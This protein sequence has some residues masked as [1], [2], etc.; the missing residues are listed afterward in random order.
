MT[1]TATATS[2]PRHQLPYI[3][4]GQ[5]QKETTHNEALLRIDALLQ[6]I[7][8]AEIAVPPA[9]QA[10]TQPG[11]CWLIAASIPGAPGEWAGKQGQIACWNGYGWHYIIPAEMMRIKNKALSADMVF[12]LGIWSAPASIA[13][14]T[15][16]SVIDVEARSI[17]NQLLMRL[18]NAGLILS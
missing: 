7:V 2:T 6:P 17:I 15:G 4:T 18:R 3:A 9:I 10:G 8:E 5:A 13:D 11:K 12:A 1:A 16:G 14:V